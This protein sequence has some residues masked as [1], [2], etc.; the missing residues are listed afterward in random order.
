MTASSQ[1]LEIKSILPNKIE[2]AISILKRISNSTN[3]GKNIKCEDISKE[4]NISP[5]YTEQ[6]ISIL[7]KN[8][9]V[10]SRG[11]PGGGYK[12]EENN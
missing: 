8:G 11:G 4:L 10:K 1:S 12:L 9:Y 7:R 5:S 2:I 6:I 3:Q